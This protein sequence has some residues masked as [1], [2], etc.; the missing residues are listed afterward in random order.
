[1]KTVK[2]LSLVLF[3][4]GIISTPAFAA[5]VATKVMVRA[6]SRDAKIIGTHVGGAKITIRDASTGAVLA[7][8]MQ[9]G[10]T[11][12]TQKIIVEPRQR[13]ATVYDTEGA[14][15]Y[16]ATLDLERP[17]MVEIT[18]EGPL[19]HPQATA[20]TSKTLLL[21]PGKDVLGEGV[22][23]EIHGFIVEPVGI[24]SDDAIH[25]GQ[26]LAVRA[27]VVMACGCP[28]EPGGLWDSNHIQVVALLL[29]GSEPVAETELAFAG[30]TSHY[31]GSL[32]IPSAGDYTLELRAS[33]PSN[34][35]F[36]RH[37]T[38]LKVVQ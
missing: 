10:G 34:A 6:V 7:E 19:G 31:S 8:G 29:K 20:K 16:L 27:T 18:A 13:H 22:L 11:G 25:A 23:L 17:T 5:G 38:E 26:P 35:N 4:A 33:D 36:G 21:F 15:G 30:E 32:D 14:A 2:T 24:S 9:M 28:T 1:M 3:A 12:N 37:R